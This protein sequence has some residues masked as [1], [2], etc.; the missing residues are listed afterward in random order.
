MINHRQS[1]ANATFRERIFHGVILNISRKGKG[2]QGARVSETVGQAP[3]LGRAG[4]S[5]QGGAAQNITTVFRRHGVSSSLPS[6]MKC[7][8]LL[9]PQDGEDQVRGSQGLIHTLP[10]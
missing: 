4:V 3:S 1:E 9:P 6:P 2:P 5:G 7:L 8:F 10:L